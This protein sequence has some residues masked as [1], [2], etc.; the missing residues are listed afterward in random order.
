MGSITLTI[1]DPRIAMLVDASFSTDAGDVVSSYLDLI[2]H[3]LVDL[4]QDIAS[5]YVQIT[6]ATLSEPQPYSA[7]Q[8]ATPA[9]SAE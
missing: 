4:S 1:S 5:G 9:L 7:P 2:R 3:G 6:S 8:A